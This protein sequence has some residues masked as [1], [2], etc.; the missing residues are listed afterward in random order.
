MEEQHSLL[1]RPSTLLGPLSRR[2][3]W[4]PLTERQSL[5]WA[6]DQLFE[7]N[8]YHHWVLW[9]RFDGE[10]GV[11]RFQ[12]AWR[13]TVESH[14]ALAL[15][16]DTR[17]PFQRFAV[18]LP[19]LRLVELP[20]NVSV[21]H[22]V[23]E[24][25]TNNF[26]PSRQPWEAALVQGANGEL[27]FVFRAH[28]QVC[29]EA[30]FY[31][32]ATE[33]NSRYEG[34]TIPACG[35]MRE[36]VSLGRHLSNASDYTAQREA[37][38]RML[39]DP[40]SIAVPLGCVRSNDEL[41]VARLSRW[42]S[43][44]VRDRIHACAQSAAFRAEPTCSFQDLVVLTLTFVWLHALS[45]QTDL[46]VSIA[47]DQRHDATTG[48]VGLLSDLSYLRVSIEEGETFETLAVKVG[49]AVR[50][51]RQ[52]S[53]I[54]LGDPRCASAFVGTIPSWPS[55][56]CGNPACYRMGSALIFASAGLGQGDGRCLLAVRQ[57]LEG[58]ELGLLFDFERSIYSVS[59]RE[60]LV[61]YYLNLLTALVEDPAQPL[62]AVDWLPPSEIEQLRQ[63]GEGRRPDVA[64][65][66]LERFAH[67]VGATPGQIAVTFQG[68]QL[69][70]EQLDRVTNRL[71]RR[72][73]SLGVRKESRVAVAMPRGVGELVALLATL[74]AQGAYVAVDPTHPV[75]RVRVIL[76]DAEPE[77]LIAPSNSPLIQALPGGAV[78]CSLDDF[79][80]DS[81]GFSEAALE[82]SGLSEDQL[83][84]ILFTSG[85]T[86][87]PKGVE[88]TRDAFANFLQSMSHE[89][90]MVRSDCVLAITTTTFDIAGLELFLPLYVGASIVIADKDTAMDPL[91][92][93]TLIERSDISVMQATPATW[94][95]LLDTGWT[96]HPR[97]RMLCG[98]EAMSLFLAQ[99]LLACGAELWNVYGPTETT[100]WS[101]IERVQSGVERITIGH[102]IDHTRIDLRDRSG[103]LVALGAIGEICIGGRGLARGYRGRPDLT[104]ERFCFDPMTGQRYYR[105]GD[106]GRYLQDGRLE[107]LG[108]V[109]HQVKIRG[110]RIEPADV[111]A[112]L[113][114]V[115]GVKEVL[116]LAV[117]NGEDDPQLVAYWVGEAAQES[118]RNAAKAGLPRYMVPSAYVHLGAFPLTTSG[119]IDRKQLP[120]PDAAQ[121][122]DAEP[123]AIA[124]RNDQESMLASM[125]REILGLPFVPVNKDFFSLGGTSVR[126]VQLR[127][128]I[129]DSLGIDLPLRVLFER[130]T[131][132]GLV[133]SLDT[134]PNPDDPVVSWT[135]KDAARPPWI[136]IMG[137]HLFEDIAR[138]FPAD[139]PFLAMHVPARYVPL[140]DPFPSVVE[141]ARKYVAVI[142]KELPH[143]PYFL[144]GLCHGGVVAFEVA[145]QLE[146]LGER[147]GAVGLLD[148]ELPSARRVSRATR[149]RSIF[150]KFL[151]TPQELGR[152]AADV[153][154]KGFGAAKSPKRGARQECFFDEAIDMPFDGPEI[155]E[156]LRTYEGLSRCT[157]AHV[158]TFRATKS[159][160]PPWII[161]D[162]DLG[163]SG[164]AGH[165]VSHDIASSHLG[166]VREQAAL[167][168]AHHLN[169]L[170]RTLGC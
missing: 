120:G 160:L 66:L 58:Q 112:Q 119:K 4:W 42:V 155:D 122:A 27:G 76:E 83:A 49:N 137:V 97:L 31:L 51:A 16:V 159:D 68:T 50:F 95:L 144:L 37:W 54:S 108:R 55:T 48:T 3:E 100:V 39:G 157:Q 29:D 101:T 89:P 92:L 21:E 115:P 107:C 168:V 17:K 117:S 1:R 167:Q 106:L 132:E 79:E 118:L 65:D 20:E 72:L 104:A 22:W 15:I 139:Q 53:Q 75:E 90:G 78:F 114:A 126:A 59:V 77:A 43:P 94:R 38:E 128:R 146:Q 130:P 156:E 147:V 41:G 70:Y 98:G 2:A 5:V 62:A 153:L 35:Q 36:V 131:V 125:F 149:V 23:A 67:W 14:D 123:D 18:G 116:V 40:P 80:Y 44:R 145:I 19:E 152:Q 57:V 52:N 12:R 136:G 9:I 93:R 133:S 154:E 110:F 135:S 87:R 143:G 69:T 45:G 124:P 138:A 56:F 150:E 162:S 161:V 148:A 46:V 85:S 71:S 8:R 30:S 61:D 141:L 134:C 129:A 64:P 103:R 142:R 163:W 33:V 47:L 82:N 169:E 60:R 111:E 10:I 74:K 32:I 28:Y 6:D 13:E 170:K 7:E 109:D 73:Q 151:V 158:I 34:R 121:R 63:F 105:T 11:E 99:R 164:R 127:A 88:I 24:Q 81:A 102:A 84:Y 91:Q 140:I 165:L 26:A 25:V 166:I 113:R 96:G 86:G